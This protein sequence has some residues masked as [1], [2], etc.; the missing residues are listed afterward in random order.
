MFDEIVF[1]AFYRFFSS[2]RRNHIIAK[3][4]GSD[5]GQRHCRLR[6]VLAH[7][8]WRTQSSAD[9]R[10]PHRHRPRYIGSTTRGKRRHGNS[11]FAQ[12]AIIR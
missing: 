7:D 4:D 3:T 5:R 10:S 2:A 6:R 1:A 12:T 8:S 11:H 9:H